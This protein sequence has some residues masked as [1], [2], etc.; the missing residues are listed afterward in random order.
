MTSSAI[1][2]LTIREW[3][4]LGFW[5][6]FTPEVGWKIH[7]HRAG[8]EKL[9]KI[10]DKYVANPFNVNVSE[11]EHLGPY[12]YLKIVTWPFPEINH[13]GI[14]GSLSDLSRLAVL[15]RAWANS[16][17]IGN[18]YQVSQLFSAASTAELTLIMEHDGFSPGDYD[19]Q[20]NG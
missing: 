5:Y 14:Y 12:M 13:D 9:G 19:A 17:P 15:V 7:G 18:R 1:R 16:C 6:D 20:V 10:F 8:F 2:E 11:H 4:D 3:N